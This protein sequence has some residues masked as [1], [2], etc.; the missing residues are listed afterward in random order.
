MKL[1]SRQEVI[2]AKNNDRAR[3]V[4]EGLKLARRVDDLRATQAQEEAALEKF[5][6]ETLSAIHEE[7][8]AKII[9][10]DALCGEVRTLEKRKAE[11]LQPLTEKEERIKEEQE[12]L[13]RRE[14]AIRDSESA[15]ESAWKDVAV[16][17]G[18]V[19][20]ARTGAERDREASRLSYAEAVSDREAAKLALAD[21]DRL[22]EEAFRMREA[23]EK[24]LLLRDAETAARERS[25]TMKLAKVAE[26]HEQLNKEWATLRDRQKR[27]Q[28][29]ITRLDKKY[30][31]KYR[32][33]SGI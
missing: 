21:A 16:A 26:E 13:A 11:A 20:R 6:R 31:I 15:I 12:A 28:A 2:T 3:E 22:K 10:R 32:G 25:A 4:A 33:D 17:K 19:D 9:E 1:L 23:V 18:S 14:S 5:R 29:F 24:E 8:E 27:L 7:I 30:G